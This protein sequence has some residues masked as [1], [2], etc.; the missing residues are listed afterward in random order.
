MAQ[1]RVSKTVLQYSVDQASVN[2]VVQSTDQMA[3]RLKEL[4]DK[5]LILTRTNEAWAHSMTMSGDS[6]RASFDKAEKQVTRLSQRLAAAK[7]QAAGNYN[8]LRDELMGGG[9][10]GGKTPTSG[11]RLSTESLRRTGGALSQLG[12][13]AIGEPVSRLGDVAEIAKTASTGLAAAGV[14]LGSVAAVAAPVAVAVAGAALAIK[15]FNDNM[16]PLQKGVN[17]G[18]ARLKAYYQIIEEGT[19]A[20]INIAIKKL[21]LE[22]RLNDTQMAKLMQAQINATPKDFFGAV[23]G[24]V[25]RLTGQYASQDARI[26]ELAESSE[27][28]QAQ[29]DANKDALK[30]GEVA[31][32]DAADA[33]QRL[34]EIRNQIIDKGIQRDIE[35]SK[36]LRT[37]KPDQVKDLIADRE[38]EIRAIRE[39]MNEVDKESEKYKELEMRLKDAQQWLDFYNDTLKDAAAANQAAANAAKKFEE[40][41]KDQVSAS[42]KR[43]ADLESAAQKYNEDIKDLDSQALEERAAIQQRYNDKIVDLAR[44]AADEAA[45]ARIKLEESQNDILKGFIRDSEKEQRELASSALDQQIKAARE[46][47]KAARDHFRELERIRADAADREFD[48]ILNRDF[49][50]LFQS[51]RQTT[52]DLLRANADFQTGRDERQL[53]NQQELEDERRH[54]AEARNERQIAYAQQI[55]DAQQAYRREIQQSQ[56]KHQAQLSLAYMEYTAELNAQAA[57]I[58]KKR[59]ILDQNYN[60]EVTMIQQ[61]YDARMKFLIAER[62]AVYMMTGVGRGATGSSSGGRGPSHTVRTAA[63][64]AMLDPGMLSVVH[65]GETF[66]GMGLFYALQGGAVTNNINSNFSISGGN[67]EMIW[68]AIEPKIAQTVLRLIS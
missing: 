25:A 7:S 6:I 17:Q 14:S 67:P 55:G 59:V 26:K 52:R 44:T 56:E 10:T 8:A 30:S 62:D 11:A 4:G 16:E 32:N 27:N 61:V 18:I 47:E 54:I 40:N 57:A 33:E 58:S 5:T 23:A 49:L 9:A 42:E 48:L 3:R 24:G 43:N 66:P 31:A 45:Q 65:G 22:K 35:Q 28:Y 21:E 64:G 13:G 1:D 29:I 34:A 20:S 46:D 19:T 51:R 41:S 12:L 63:G 68:R 39:R 53:A 15:N 37:A 50:G 36:L 38:D 60:A 2:R